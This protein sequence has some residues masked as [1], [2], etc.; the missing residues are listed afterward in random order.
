MK[1]KSL[2]L[3]IFVALATQ[4]TAAIVETPSFTV[5]GLHYYI[6]DADA[7]TVSVMY[8]EYDLPN[9]EYVTDDY[10]GDITIPE[11]VT[12]GGTTY[13][14]TG[15]FNHAF[16]GCT[17]LASVILP[18]TITVIG[19]EAFQGCTALTTM[20]IPST[21][22]SIEKSAFSHCSGIT[23]IVIPDATTEFGTNIF[24]DCTGLTSITLPAGI[25]TIANS[26]FSGCT[27]FTEFEIPSSVTLLDGGAFNGCAGL[28]K[29]TIG[30]GVKTIG[31]NVFDGCTAMEEIIVDEENENYASYDG[32]LYTK[33]FATL[34]QIALA[35]KTVT[36]KEGC[37][38]FDTSC[39]ANAAVEVLN[40][41]STVNKFNGS[42]LKPC[43][44]LKEVNYPYAGTT[45][46]KL[47][48]TSPFDTSLNPKPVLNIPAGTASYFSKAA[49]KNAFDIQ[50]ATP[51]A[52]SN[53]TAAGAEVKEIYT[54]G[55]VRANQNAK[56][57]VIIRM[58]DGSVKKAAK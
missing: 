22:T 43:K 30:K 49:W 33:D 7:K 58:T 21:V 4:I 37:T 15:I 17:E 18:Q 55:G 24:Q 26:M 54:I 52:I 40:I 16:L 25:E 45:A 2:L 23:S 28:T 11:S 36:I 3:S 27:G 32:C 53:A 10:T 38:T 1:F 47:P 42:S 50:E 44:N 31:T 6:T 8:K 51:D 9:H 41:A 56:G 34:K 19:E 5:G 57:A 46:P 14:V 39:G 29:I 20:R 13:T 12:D 48:F 35:K